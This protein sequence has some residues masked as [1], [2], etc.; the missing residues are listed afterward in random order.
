MVDSRCVCVCACVVC[1]CVCVL[2]VR[3]HKPEGGGLQVRMCVCVVVLHET[4]K[5]IPVRLVA[6][7]GVNFVFHTA[8]VRMLA[9]WRLVLRNPVL[10]VPWFLM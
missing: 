7:L 8:H 10:T 6:T 5:N 1:V 2:C 9:C 3:S 4:K